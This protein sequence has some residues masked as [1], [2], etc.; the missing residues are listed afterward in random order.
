MIYVP[1]F[2]APRPSPFH[3][4]N[5]GI[6]WL[7]PWSLFATLRT[8]LCNLQSGGASWR[9]SE[10]FSMKTPSPDSGAFTR[11][12]TVEGYPHTLPRMGSGAQLQASFVHRRFVVV[13]PRGCIPDFG[14]FYGSRG[15]CEWKP[16]SPKTSLIAHAKTSS[17]TDGFYDRNFHG[18]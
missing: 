18:S 15:G 5:P 7:K 14:R 12:R 8:F 6:H 2:Y 16:R 17:P 4:Q 11:T 1:H 13:A 10:P 3:S 9:K